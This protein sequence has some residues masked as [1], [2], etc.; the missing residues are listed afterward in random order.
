M[1]INIQIDLSD[2]QR[3]LI[4]NFLDGKTN[5]RK[6]SRKDIVN[7]VQSDLSGLLDSFKLFSGKPKSEVKKSKQNFIF[8][9]T[10]EFKKAAAD[11]KKIMGSG[12]IKE[13][14]IRGWVK[15]PFTRK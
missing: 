15:E 4:A 12:F 6:A 5:K 9:E 1:K 10:D 8:L 11:K 2:E 3:S 7:I 14:Y 13:N